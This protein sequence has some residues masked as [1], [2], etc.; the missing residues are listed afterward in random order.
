MLQRAG[1]SE[2]TVDRSTDSCLAPTFAAV[3]SRDCGAKALLFVIGWAVLQC[4]SGR[5]N[6]QVWY[7]VLGQVGSGTPY[8]LR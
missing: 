3:G 8:L 5:W 7:G 4:F 6:G 2:P 1:A